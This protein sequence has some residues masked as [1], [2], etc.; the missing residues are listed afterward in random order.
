MDARARQQQSLPALFAEI[1]RA[2]EALHEGRRRGESAATA[3]GRERQLHQ[4]LNEYAEALAA[5]RIPVPCV[6]RDEL[7]IYRDLL[8]AYT[9]RRPS[10]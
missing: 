2:R 4:A 5:L 8:G 9:D 1:R 10:G 3:R 7:R 6:I